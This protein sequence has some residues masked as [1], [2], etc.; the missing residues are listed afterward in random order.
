MSMEKLEWT[1]VLLHLLALAARL[2]GE[3]Q[4]NLAKLA[5]AAADAM[6]RRAAYQLAIPSDKGKLVAEI[7]QAVAALSRLDADEGLLTALRRGATAMSEGRLP[8]IDETPHPYICRTCGHV[9]LSE[10]EKCPTCGA[11]PATFQ[12]F[13]PVYWLDALDPPAAL[14]KL[15]QTP[16]AVAALLEGL[17]EDLMTQ[18]PEDG[19]AVFDIGAYELVP[20][21]AWVYLPLLSR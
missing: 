10:P 5:R 17:S 21:V 9:A 13:P 4:Y 6:S 14:E 8:L 15:R 7:E 19:S 11:W 1:D 16:L 3:G 18:Q 12:L 2:E 20:A